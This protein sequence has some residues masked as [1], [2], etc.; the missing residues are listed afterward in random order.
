MDI[1]LVYCLVEQLFCSYRGRIE[2][3]YLMTHQLQYAMKLLIFFIVVLACLLVLTKLICTAHTYK[4][5]L[6]IMLSLVNAMI[7]YSISFISL[8]VSIRLSSVCS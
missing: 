2:V 8:K 6:V 7:C 3:S 1:V 5:S 4:F